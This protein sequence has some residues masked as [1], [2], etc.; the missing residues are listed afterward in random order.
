VRLTLVSIALSLVALLAADL[1]AQ[2][3]GRRLLGD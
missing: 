2:R 3:L 1:L